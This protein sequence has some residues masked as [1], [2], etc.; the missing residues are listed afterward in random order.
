[1]QSLVHLIILLVLFAIVI[2]LGS[3]LYHL[4]RGPSRGD[5]QKMVRALSVRIGLSLALFFLLMILWYAG[6]IEPHG[7][8]PH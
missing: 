1:M 4:A 5:S 8:Q 7:L 3:A 6:F 2:S